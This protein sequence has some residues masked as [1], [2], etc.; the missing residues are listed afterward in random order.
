[1][2][3]DVL[4]EVVLQKEFSPEGTEEEEILKKLKKKEEKAEKTEKPKVG[5]PSKKE[6][7]L[8][9]DTQ[10]RR[11]ATK[12]LT[13]DFRHLLGAASEV[14][15][16]KRDPK[17]GKRHYLVTLDTPDLGRFSNLN[18]YIEAYL[19]PKFG[20]GEY[21]A[22]FRVKQSDGPDEIHERVVDTGID[23]A[24]TP[25]SQLEQVT[26]IHDEIRKLERER[27]ELMKQH[28]S[29]QINA[30][31]KKIQEYQQKG[32]NEAALAP[33][34]EEIYRLKEQQIA[35]DRQLQWANL[36]LPVLTPFLQS[37]IDKGK[38]EKD[39]L[40]TALKFMSV[41]ET[42]RQDTEKIISAMEKIG[43][44]KSLVDQL[45]ERVATDPNNIKRAIDFMLE[46][47]KTVG[48]RIIDNL[49]GNPSIT[50]ILMDRLL[51][52]KEPPQPSPLDK[53]TDWVMK[54]PQVIMQGLNKITGADEIKKEINVL[55]EMAHKD[56]I[57]ETIETMRGLKEIMEIVSPPRPAAE[58]PKSPMRQMLDTMKEMKE[59]GEVLKPLWGVSET[60]WGAITSVFSKVI[61]GLAPTLQK[62]AEGYASA[63]AARLYEVQTKLRG[64]PLK[65]EVP[66]SEVKA[67]EEVERPPEVKER[68]ETPET[69]E[70]AVEVIKKPEKKTFEEIIIHTVH[71]L[72]ESG[73]V[74]DADSLTANISKNLKE[75]MENGE[76]ETKENLPDELLN[77][78]YKVIP[79]YKNYE[80]VAK[81]MVN[82]ILQ[83]LGA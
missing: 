61:E 11:E 24:E 35:A 7:A 43:Q 22:Q 14:A 32:Y 8:K 47:K 76:V 77:A 39:V 40:D 31:E 80:P 42:R 78:L 60:K 64:L 13:K 41:L 51:P 57:S 70:K 2:A 81:T 18:E 30:L 12:E 19:V 75:A 10:L 44:N 1:M 56:R 21:V 53:L 72:A 5:R 52:K 9:L 74:V 38:G 68:P 55:R 33:L 59:L 45:V 79:D 67:E 29:E 26:K 25:E 16:Y 63:Q 62:I 69:I 65:P 58:P 3:K 83:N 49:L 50:G 54:N 71:E 48:D 46:A 37:M 66:A 20:R 73:K 34:R 28:F 15:F 17:F 4:D 23:F 6:E 36:L 27:A 82:N